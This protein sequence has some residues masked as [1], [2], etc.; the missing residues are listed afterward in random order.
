MNSTRVE[1][2][3]QYS[4]GH[5]PFSPDCDNMTGSP[6]TSRACPEG[7]ATGRLSRPPRDASGTREGNNHTGNS[8]HI[9]RLSDSGK[10]GGTSAEPCPYLTCQTPPD[11]AP[12]PRPGTGS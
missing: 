2:Y 9:P 3:A 12:S 4:G 1:G 8:R 11:N 10:E 7:R 5:K 6:E